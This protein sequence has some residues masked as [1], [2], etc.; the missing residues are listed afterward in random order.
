MKFDILHRTRYTYA[1]PVRESF[2]ELRLLPVSTESQRVED[3]LLKVLPASPLRHYRDFYSNC[4]HH[5]EVPQE[6]TSLAIESHLRVT[7]KPALGLSP[8]ARP[9]ALEQL[10]QGLDVDRCHDFIQASRFVDT[11][12]ETWRLAID[13]TNGESDTW[14]CALRLMQFVHGQIAYRSYSTQ[15]HTTMSEVL[16]QKTGVCQDFAHVMIG[17]CRTL[18]IPALYVSGYMAT[19]QAN[20]T[21]AWVE[22]FIPGAGWQALDPTHDR[23]ADERYVKI[24]VG[25]DYGDVAPVKGTYKGTITRTMNVEV[26]IEIV[27]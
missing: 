7:T 20:A 10:R 12:P 4:V 16:V 1:Q 22:V 21:H 13:A 24:A 6:H 8:N 18:R 5:F 15:V 27:G 26:R 14:Q 9:A 2:N 11:A 23:I 25:R 3:F 17:L 19:E